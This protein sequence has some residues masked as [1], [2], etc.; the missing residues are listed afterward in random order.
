M[1]LP[2][3]LL[4]NDKA[5]PCRQ[6]LGNA[7]KPSPSY[8]AAT[9]AAGGGAAATGASATPTVAYTNDLYRVTDSEEGGVADYGP[10][11]YP[12]AEVGGGAN[13]GEWLSIRRAA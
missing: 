11:A 6:D 7:A 12:P 8:S 5:T 3:L 9:A 4:T 1:T 2:S 13:R 10:A